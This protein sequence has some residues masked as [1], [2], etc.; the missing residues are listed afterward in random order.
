MKHVSDARPRTLDGPQANCSS[1]GFSSF[2]IV[3]LF[4]FLRAFFFFFVVMAVS[5]TKARLFSFPCLDAVPLLCSRSILDSPRRYFV[6]TPGDPSCA[7]ASADR[8]SYSSPAWY[9]GN[10]SPA[11]PFSRNLATSQPILNFPLTPPAASSPPLGATSLGAPRSLTCP[12]SPAPDLSCEFPSLVPAHDC[13]DE[14]EAQQQAESRIAEAAQ[15]RLSR[16]ERQ[17]SC[18][19]IHAITLF[20]VFVLSPV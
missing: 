6:T 4:C 17:I 8:S 3:R 9:V 18:H 2:K 5:P 11:Y 7:A 14:E 15:V 13:A 19:R 1:P 20:V 10:R 16:V 12:E